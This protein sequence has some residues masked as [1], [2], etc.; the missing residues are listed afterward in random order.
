[1]SE[2]VIIPKHIA[3][4][5]SVDVKQRIPRIIWQ[6]MKTNEVPAVL[7]SYADTWINLNPEYEYR[8]SDN[9]DILNFIEKEFPEFLTAY[10]KIKYGASKADLWRYLVLYKYG[11]IYADLDCRCIS[12]LKNWVDPN[13]SLTTQIGINDDI[14]QWL[15]I[16]EPGNPIFIRAANEAVR[17]IETKQYKVEYRGFHLEEGKLKLREGE[18]HEVN[19]D[20]MG[21]AGPPVL[22][23]S[24]ETC[25]QNGEVDYMW[26]NIQV[27]CVSDPEKS[28]QMANNV[29]HDSGISN[30]Y[31]K[32]L[33]QLKTPYYNNFFARLMR[34][35]FPPRN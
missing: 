18:M 34:K 33:K 31:V 24:A 10:H 30:D 32:A 11:G 7:K 3:P 25:F 12:P 16:T 6:T 2:L 27:V 20:I 15:I 4:R 22:Q 35:I 23:E 28:C 17:H 21:L 13:A 9:E 8:F 29:S 26:N 5:T 1:M 19:H 14:C